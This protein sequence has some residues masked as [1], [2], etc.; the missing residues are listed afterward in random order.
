[1]FFQEPNNGIKFPLKFRHSVVHMVLNPVLLLLQPVLLLL[2]SL[3]S[4]HFS[5]IACG[6]DCNLLNL[7]LFASASQHRDV[8]SLAKVEHIFGNGQKNLNFNL[9]ALFRDK[10]NSK[11]QLVCIPLA[12][13]QCINCFSS[14]SES[15]ILLT[16]K[17]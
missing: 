10:L 15:I 5:V 16:V 13:V 14:T 4:L 12:D 2:E 6:H 7:L 1:M 11:F 17:C 9:S 3:F 8:L